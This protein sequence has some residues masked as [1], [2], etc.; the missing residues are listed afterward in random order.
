MRILAL[1]V[2][3][4]RIGVAISDP[5]GMIASPLEVI[6]RKKVKALYRIK[7]LIREN[8]VELIVSGMPKSLDGTEK[9]QA[10]KVRQF[11]EKLKQK[12]KG[13][14]IVTIDERYS[15]VSADKILN[16]SNR[17]GAIEKRKVVD[18]VAATVI[19]QTYLDMKK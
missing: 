3:D 6:D 2:G 11:L 18:K 1:D 14:E 19:L 13:I 16:F 17:K 12:I 7:D 10:Q 5:M 9:I 15:T 8:N 4:V